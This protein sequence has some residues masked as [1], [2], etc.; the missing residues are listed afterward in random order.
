MF[1]E[2]P[3]LTI[4]TDSSGFGWGAHLNNYPLEGLWTSSEIDDHINVKELRAILRALEGFQNLIENRSVLVRTDS[5]TA[6]WYIE[7]QGGTRS[8]PCLSVTMEIWKFCIAH[9]IWL[10]AEHVPGAENVQ[11]DFL[12]RYIITC[13]KFS[14]KLGCRS[15][16]DHA[17]WML[18]ATV[19]S[20]IIA[21]FHPT[22]DLFAST[23]NHRLPRYVTWRYAEGSVATDAFR[24]CWSDEVPYIFPP[25]RL[26]LRALWKIRTEHVRAIII[27]PDWPF[28]PYYSVL[29]SMLLEP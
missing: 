6:F 1:H 2:D 26:V 11:A 20:S 13:V 7:K 18:S 14:S 16:K 9:G 17:E 8:P 12:S 15:L 25:I 29:M 24:I 22:V 28:Q 3:S 21:K 4:T 23:L 5:M 10:S 27:A 19:M